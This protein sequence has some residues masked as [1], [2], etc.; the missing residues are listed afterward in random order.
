[1]T[2]R[3][4]APA[5]GRV[6]RRALPVLV[7]ACAGVLPFFMGG[8][9]AGAATAA[10]TAAKSSSAGSAV[11]ARRALRAK[12]FHVTRI[13][14]RAGRTAARCTWTATRGS[15]TCAGKLTVRRRARYGRRVRVGTP[16]CAADP[17]G[18]TPTI[19]FGFNEYANDLTVRVQKPTGARVMRINVAWSAVEQVPG[20]FDWSSIDQ[21]YKVLIDAGLQPLMFLVGAPCWARPSTTCAPILTGAPDPAFDTAWATFV[22]EAARRYPRAI[23]FEIWNEENLDSQ[24]TPRADATRYTQL[25]KEAYA[26]AKSVAPSIPVISGGLFGS[27]APGRVP[28]GPDD[29]TPNAGGYG[30]APFLQQMY[31]AGAGSAMDG[32][33]IHPYPYRY[34]AAGGARWDPAAMDEA[35]ARIRAVRAAAGGTQPLWITELGES[36]A[37]QTGQPAAVTPTQQASDLLRMVT[38]VAGQSDVALLIIHTLIDAAPSPA[39]DTLND[40]VAAFTGVSVSYNKV[41]TGFGIFANDGKPK[42][43]ACALNKPF[44]GTLVC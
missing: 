39:V 19:A 32:I 28:G 8:A 37:T 24:F 20:V 2:E 35:L 4:D 9:S 6:R 18:V 7:A 23:A 14:C 43:A 11:T 12:G 10:A 41:N 16:R 42:P 34:D 40:I 13:S 44:G 17:A 5:G 31:A 1:M 36:T 21:Q 25:L 3:A 15:D 29:K 30:D 33:G 27:P 22:R 38:T 26:A